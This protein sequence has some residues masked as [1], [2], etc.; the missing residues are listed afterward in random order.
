MT[1]LKEHNSRLFEP[2]TIGRICLKHRIVLA[3]LTRCRAD[4][5]HVPLVPLMAEYYSQ[6]ASLPGTLLISEAN[7]ISPRAG[8][9]GNSPG[10]WNAEQL[11][12]WK[13]ITNAVHAKGS[14][15]YAQL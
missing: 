9:Y 1:S 4:E 5:N 6:R 3:P 7:I 13:E 12:A 15:I 14:F 10:L 8:S 11:K 2:L